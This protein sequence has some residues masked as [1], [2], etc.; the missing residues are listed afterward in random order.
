MD[1]WQNRTIKKRGRRATGQGETR[2]IPLELLAIVE[3]L[4]TAP[5]QLLMEIKKLLGV[6]NARRN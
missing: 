2:Y 5:P 1:L 4:K 3:K 6:K